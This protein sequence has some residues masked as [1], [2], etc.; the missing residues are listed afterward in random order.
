[1]RWDQPVLVGLIVL[2]VLVV[3]GRLMCVDQRGPREDSH[4]SEA[5]AGLGSPPSR[6]L[7][8]GPS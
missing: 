3:W 6:A 1:M 8:G 4:Y 2:M 5:A 7:S